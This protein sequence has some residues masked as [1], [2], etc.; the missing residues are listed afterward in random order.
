MLAKKWRKENT[1][2]IPVGGRTGVR[3]RV[4]LSPS[5]RFLF[6]VCQSFFTS[7]LARTNQARTEK[8]NIASVGHERELSESIRRCHLAHSNEWSFVRVAPV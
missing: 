6:D 1:C 5:S 3:G 8:D 2:S 7:W 4:A